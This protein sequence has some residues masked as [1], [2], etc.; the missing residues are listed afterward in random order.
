MMPGQTRTPAKKAAPKAK[1]PS[2]V[3]RE[4]QQKIPNITLACGNQACSQYGDEVTAPSG[5]VVAP[6]VLLSGVLSCMTC[7]FHMTVLGKAREDEG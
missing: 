5:I 1:T 3:L 6:G 2:Q 4:S 7:G